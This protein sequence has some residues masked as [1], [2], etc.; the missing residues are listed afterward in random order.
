MVGGGRLSIRTTWVFEYAAY[1]IIV[2]TY[3]MAPP[4]PLITVCDKKH[5]VSGGDKH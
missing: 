2:I 5:R 4:R 1:I 3:S